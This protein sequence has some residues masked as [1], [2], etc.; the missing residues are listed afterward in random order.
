MS[1][2]LDFGGKLLVGG[3]GNATIHLGGKSIEITCVERRERVSFLSNSASEFYHFF[4][5][6]DQLSD[7]LQETIRSYL[8]EAQLEIDRNKPRYAANHRPFHDDSPKPITI[9]DD[10]QLVLIHHQVLL[11][12]YTKKELPSLRLGRE[13][14]A[15]A[16][17]PFDEPKYS[18]GKITRMVVHS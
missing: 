7:S 14:I 10:Y 17:K 16:K 18:L 8:I 2:T 1:L 4:V 11:Q 6:I 15:Y 5:T 9:P 13:L 3:N 12:A